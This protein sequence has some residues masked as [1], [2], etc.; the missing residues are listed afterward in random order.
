MKGREL[1][2]APVLSTVLLTCYV[3]AEISPGPWMIPGLIY[4]LLDEPCT[5]LNIQLTP[6]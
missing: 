4:T 1:A 3:A 2:P 5:A 6:R